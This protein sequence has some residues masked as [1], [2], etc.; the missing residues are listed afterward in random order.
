[1]DC[2]GEA[3]SLRFSDISLTSIGVIHLIRTQ[4]FPKNE[5]FLPPD[6]YQGVRNVHFSEN[7]AYVL[8]NG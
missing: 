4:D 1:M 2:K 3:F 8:I 7:F 5:H 6:I